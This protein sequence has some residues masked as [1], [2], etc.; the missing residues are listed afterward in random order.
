MSVCLK[1]LRIALCAIGRR[2]S[3]PPTYSHSVEI[4]PSGLTSINFKNGCP[5]SPGTGTLNRQTSLYHPL[6]P[7]KTVPPLGHFHSNFLINKLKCP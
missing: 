6:N 3:R 2:A 7:L 1:P 5:T 4:H